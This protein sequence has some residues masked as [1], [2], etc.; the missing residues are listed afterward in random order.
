M[1]D[2]HV[3]LLLGDSL[4]VEILAQ[5]HF[6]YYSTK[7]LMVHMRILMNIQ[8][9]I[10]N[11]IEKVWLLLVIYQIFPFLEIYNLIVGKNAPK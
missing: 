3:F 10:K 1:C 9:S 6:L 2:F 8:F 7:T 5:N 11:K 4:V